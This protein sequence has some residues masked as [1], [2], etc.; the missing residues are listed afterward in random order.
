[1][2]GDGGSYPNARF[3]MVK[4]KKAD[5][6]ADP[7][8]KE[9]I[10]WTT[11][12]ISRELFKP[13]IVADCLGNIFNKEALITALLEKTLPAE[14]KHLKSLKD[15]FLVNF[16]PNPS[17]RAVTERKSAAV[18][19]VGTDFPFICPI[20]GLEVGGKHKFSV[21]KACG[22][23]LS[24]R[25]LKECFSEN[26]LV[27]AK[28]CKAE[29]IIP[30]NPDE[31]D[32][33]AL[34][35]RMTSSSSGSNGKHHHHEKKKHQPHD[36]ELKEQSKDNGKE[37]ESSTSAS[38]ATATAATNNTTAT[39]ENMS[40]AAMDQAEDS[41]KRKSNSN[42]LRTTQDASSKKAKQ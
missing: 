28:P 35:A 21:M 12:P 33:T 10:R 29:D 34:K 17:Y 39:T 2:G 4:L 11:D 14:F 30:L 32:Y 42:V 13:P 7:K 41:K 38:N 16:K 36:S 8:A 9:R 31:S 3:D 20:T 1:M 40:S 22:C 26:C 37:E 25:A 27:C 19:D 23:A 15:V 24:D 6:K 5:P 18:E